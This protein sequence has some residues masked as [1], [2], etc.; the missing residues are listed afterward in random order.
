MHLG[1]VLPP[2]R[3]L[4]LD[5]DGLQQMDLLQSQGGRGKFAPVCGMRHW[6]VQS[7]P[8]NKDNRHTACCASTHHRIVCSG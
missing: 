8:A 2:T 4:Y 7:T 1:Q 3:L 6:R 5:V